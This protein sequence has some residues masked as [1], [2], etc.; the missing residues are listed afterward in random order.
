MFQKSHCHRCLQA[1]KLAEAIRSCWQ[2]AVACIAFVFPCKK[3]HLQLEPPTPVTAFS[4][5]SLCLW[6]RNIPKTDG[7]I[8]VPGLSAA[9]PSTFSASGALS[10]AQAGFVQGRTGPSFLCSLQKHTAFKTIR[11]HLNCQGF[12]P[13]VPCCLPLPQLSVV[14]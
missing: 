6:P 9:F 1:L 8:Q 12:P 10:T 3:F 2:Q 5:V 4:R 14:A 7:K 13:N 11:K